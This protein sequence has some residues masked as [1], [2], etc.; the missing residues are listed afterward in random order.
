[1]VFLRL[2]LR[3]SLRNTTKPYESKKSHHDW[4]RNGEQVS[5]R[6]GIGRIRMPPTA[7]TNLSA[8]AGVS[9]PRCH[10]RATQS[11]GLRRP[12]LTCSCTGFLS[13]KCRSQLAAPGWGLVARTSAGAETSSIP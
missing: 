1:V 10:T 7:M 12:S 9:C 6:F 2:R 11:S 8:S 3:L 5:R 13:G 4:T